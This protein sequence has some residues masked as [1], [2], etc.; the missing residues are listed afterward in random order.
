MVFL[1]EKL[2]KEDCLS[3]GGCYS[4]SL[5]GYV[6]NACSYGGGWWNGY[7]RYNPKKNEDHI[8][9]AAR[10]LTKQ[11]KNFKNLKNSYFIHSDYRNYHYLPESFIYCDPPYAG[12]KTYNKDGFDH[13]AFWEWCRVMSKKGHKVMISEYTAPSDFICI[14]KKERK[15][16]MGTTAEGEKQNIKVE[17]VF[18]HQSLITKFNF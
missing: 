18:I 14:W 17:K 9:E 13:E 5:L 1:L 16:G 4:P 12:T 8:A 2:M 15:D 10:G 11:I 3:N 6:G 7:A